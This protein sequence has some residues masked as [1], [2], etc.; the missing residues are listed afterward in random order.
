MGNDFYKQKAEKFVFENEQKIFGMD[1]KPEPRLNLINAIKDS[2]Y[3][4]DNVAEKLMLDRFQEIYTKT[5]SRVDSDLNKIHNLQNEQRRFLQFIS[6]LS[7]IILGIPLPIIYQQTNI[8]RS[9]YIFFDG[10]VG[11]LLTAIISSFGSWYDLRLSIKASETFTEYN[12]INDEYERQQ[13]TKLFNSVV[14]DP[15]KKIKIN[16]EIK[17]PFNTQEFKTMVKYS[18]KFYRNNNKLGL[19]QI[20]FFISIMI[21]GI[22][23]LIK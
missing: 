17:E 5:D 19:I 16:N 21:I 8:I 13:A 9:P 15:S 11:L 4:N 2:F 7:L 23:F 6:S 22:S 20:L 12:S 18:N 3:K 10:L 1:L 14:I